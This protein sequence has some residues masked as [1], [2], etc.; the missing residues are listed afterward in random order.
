MKLSRRSRNSSRADPDDGL[1]ANKAE[2][3]L[4]DSL[5][6]VTPVLEEDIRQAE[7]KKAQLEQNLR[8]IEKQ[9]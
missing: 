3:S 4:Q 7:Q 5:L 6:A 9:V 8:A 1:Q 2:S